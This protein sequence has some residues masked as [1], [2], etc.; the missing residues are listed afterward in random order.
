MLVVFVGFGSIQDAWLWVDAELFKTELLILLG[1][2]N[3]C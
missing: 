3:S 2:L 1:E